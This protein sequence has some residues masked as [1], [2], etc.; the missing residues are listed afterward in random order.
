MVNKNRPKTNKAEEIFYKLS[1]NPNFQNDI[2]TFRNKFNIPENGFRKELDLKDWLAKR[3]KY[4]DKLIA[5]GK[6]TNKDSN[7]I[8]ML[9]YLL[10]Q[11]TILKKYDLPITSAS[12]DVLE[13]YILSNGGIPLS[14]RSENLGCE[15]VVP[16]EIKLQNTKQSFVEIRIYDKA[17]QSD[18]FNYVKDNWNFIKTILS[19]NKEKSKRIRIT[20]NKERDEIIFKLSRKSREK[21]GLERGNY[22]DI[23]IS[24]IM[25]E[26]YGI[27]VTPENIRKII[28]KQRKL[29]NL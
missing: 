16:E 27:Y 29:R 17:S 9:V 4:L 23:K 25:E 11:T 6:I 13:N 10:S 2:K 28:S 14:L 18:V 19:L 26:K 20:K 5:K 7:P 1:F 15:F 3:D 8:D 12:Q 22:K 24:S 21:L